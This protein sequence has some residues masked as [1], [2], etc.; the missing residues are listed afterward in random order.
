MNQYVLQ[1]NKKKAYENVDAMS[2]SEKFKNFVKSLIAKSD[3]TDHVRGI[4]KMKQDDF[5]EWEARVN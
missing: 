1:A 5:S 4:G 3:N 2:G